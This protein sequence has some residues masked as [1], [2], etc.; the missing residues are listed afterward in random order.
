[1]GMGLMKKVMK[2]IVIT[3]MLIMVI[4]GD[5]V[6]ASS[7]ITTSMIDSVCSKYGYSVGKY[8]TYKGDSNKNKYTAST[9]K[10]GVNGYKGYTYDGGSQ[11]WAFARFLMSQVAGERVGTGSWKKI[12]VANVTSLK[13]GDVVCIGDTVHTAVVYKDLGGGKFQFIEI[14]TGSYGHVIKKGGYNGTG[15]NTLSAIKNMGLKYVYRYEGTPLASIITNLKATNINSGGAKIECDVNPAKTLK[16]VQVTVWSDDQGIDKFQWITKASSVSGKHYVFD[17]K[18]STFNNQRGLYKAN[19]HVFYTDG[20]KDITASPLQFTI[21]NPP[22]ISNARATNITSNGASVECD[23]YPKKTLKAVQ[24]TVWSDVQG[25]DKFQWVTTASSVSG[26]HYKFNMLVSNFGNQRGLY[27]VN[28]H[29]FYT[30]GTKDITETPIQFTIPEPTHVHNYKFD[31]VGKQSTCVDKGYNIYKCSCGAEKVEYL[32]LVSHKETADEAVLATCTESGLS[33]GSHCEVCGKKIIVP[34]AINAKGHT[35]VIDEGIAATCTASGLT[36]GRH[37]KDCDYVLVA[38]EKI[39]M[40]EHE[41]NEGTIIESPTSIKEGAKL[42]TCNG[43]GETKIEI[44]PKLSISEEAQQPENEQPED[45]ETLP[46]IG[47]QVILS[48]GEFKITQSSIDSKEVTFVK[49]KNSKKTSVSIPA[50]ITINGYTY[51]VTEIA[52]KAFKNNKK[53]KSVTIGK[54]VTKIGKEVFSGCKKLKKIT[55]KSAVLKSVG[56]NAIKNIDKKATIKVPKKQLSK[57][58]KLFKSKTGFKKTMKIKK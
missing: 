53:L 58:K 7:G 20:T 25:I 38:Q 15:N 52:S 46:I 5:C 32:N 17:M 36:E 3:L 49:L 56:K 57:Y 37:C 31:R 35:E 33:A 2:I 29:V 55:I 45:A 10:E 30:D 51:K 54:N 43:C 39:P 26:N 22:V 21:P 6:E 8:W 18:V 19:I 9:T 4:P 40:K 44:L 47:Q 27:K 1:M 24:V 34:E 11:C 50:M 42:I 41:W 13:V 16:A 12:S 23:I 14:W 48:C 28:I